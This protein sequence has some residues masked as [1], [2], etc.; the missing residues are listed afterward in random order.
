LVV[1]P[2]KSCGLCASFQLY[3]LKFQNGSN[4][5]DVRFIFPYYLQGRNSY[6]QGP[7]NLSKT[8]LYIRGLT[9]NTT[10]QDLLNLCSNYGSIVSTKAI[11]DPMSGKCKGEKF[12]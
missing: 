10:D 1:A 7:E 4:L 6:N 3:F 9:P 2:V 11:V 12:S 5:T 8:N